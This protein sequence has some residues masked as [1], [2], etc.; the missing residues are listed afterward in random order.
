MT[1][2]SMKKINWNEEKALQLK[3]MRQIDFHEVAVMIEEK[4][5][6]GVFTVPSRK[7]QKMFVLDYDNYLVCVP[8]V[9]TEHEIFLKTAYRSRKLNKTRG[10]KKNA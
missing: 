7:E 6:L 1:H 4:K 10:R 3:K 9:E 8:F 5:F 2:A